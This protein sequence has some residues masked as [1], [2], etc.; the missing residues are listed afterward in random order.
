[1]DTCCLLSSIFRF[2]DYLSVEIHPRR[3][4]PFFTWS[5]FPDRPPFDTLAPVTG[6]GL[7]VH[8][9]SL[10]CIARSSHYGLPTP[11][12]RA[13][14]VCGVLNAGR[15]TLQ[16]FPL[17]VC[18]RIGVG[19][20]PMCARCHGTYTSAASVTSDWIDLSRGLCPVLVGRDLYMSG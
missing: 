15:V 19:V 14:H 1:M 2:Y 18:S 12:G 8:G 20:A 13:R 4:N 11:M 5:V 7:G 10:D 17:Y 3:F 6:L 16:V 9:E